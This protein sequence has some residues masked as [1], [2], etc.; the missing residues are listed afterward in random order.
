[1]EQLLSILI[2]A[3]ISGTTMYFIALH[4]NKIKRSEMMAEIQNNAIK[5]VSL[6][7]ER[8]RKDLRSELDSLKLENTKLREEISIVRSQL[9]GGE[10]LITILKEE[11]A[12]LKSTLELYKTEMVK[13]KQRLN[14]LETNGSS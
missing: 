2:P 5:T 12:S 13:S 14:S 6:I 1:M 9:I 7:E 10:H 3:F 4:R 8:I 11:I